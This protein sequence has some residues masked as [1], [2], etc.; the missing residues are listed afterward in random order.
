M[1]RNLIL[2]MALLAFLFSGNG[3]T[4]FGATIYP[5]DYWVLE[6]DYSAPFS[7]G[8]TLTVKE[9][10][11]KGR[12]KVNFMG[13]G[14]WTLGYDTSGNLLMYGATTLS[15][16]IYEVA[17]PE[18]AILL[19]YEM[20]VGEPY[21]TEWQR[22]PPD[23]AGITVY[24]IIT[25]SVSV[26]VSGPEEVSVTAGKYT[27]YKFSVID[28]WESDT[29]SEGTTKSTFW[30]AED[31]G[32]V[33]VMRDG[34]LYELQESQESKGDPPGTP[35]MRLTTSG[36]LVNV[37]WS[38]TDATGYRLFYAPYPA[39]S[40]EG[41]M[42]MR[43][44][45][46]Y[47]INLSEGA[48]YYVWAQ[49]YNNYGDSGYSNTNYH[50]V[51]DSSLSVSPSSLSISS[52][53]STGSCTISGGTGPYSAASDNTSVATVGV[54]GSTLYVTGVS[55][56]SATITVWDSASGSVTVSVTVSSISIAFSVTPTSLSISSPGSTG[57]CTISGG[58][59]PYSASAS[60]PAVAFTEVTGSTV[61]IRGVQVGNT[62]VIVQ[63]S[64]GHSTGVSVTVSDDS[65][66]T[67]TNSLGMTFILLPAGTFTMGS[68]SNEPGRNSD[69]G[70]QHQVT[71]TQPFY[72]QTT[73]VTQAQWETEMGSNPSYFSGCP[74]C[75]VE[76]VSWEDVQV[77]LRYMNARGEG[78][79]DLPTEAQWEYAARAGSTTAFYNGGITETGSEYDPNLDAIGWYTYNSGSETHP[80]GQK[81]PNSWGLY[82]MS[83]NVYELC[84]DWFSRYDSSPSTDPT[85]PS[86]G[87]SRV[88]RGGSWSYNAE[89]SRSANRSSSSPGNRYSGIGFRLVLSPGQQ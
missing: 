25:D 47:S 79:Y 61:F 8:K 42:D 55:A 20:T 46:S 12:F 89:R 65:P 64:A 43:G 51:I 86:T 75:P 15:G 81:V 28:D 23:Y 73:E 48:A 17:D 71:L 1:R 88:R 32:W 13:K 36:T 44:Q 52:P 11:V 82:D 59:G 74:T 78:T 6:D 31:V 49:A 7:F 45:T 10:A 9:T 69:E 58:T 40:F 70:P 19:P 77:F 34:I 80:V 27:A 30:L 4:A 26:T 53:G 41:S 37:S 66:G 84:R 83:G 24:T 39:R 56:G 68:P 62:T 57:S 67:F 14:T 60:N 29:G 72:M 18:R 38:A 50:F 5:G 35:T 3:F 87:T 85:G 21:K 22:K 54:S 33:K 2:L 63:D 76:Q 16:A